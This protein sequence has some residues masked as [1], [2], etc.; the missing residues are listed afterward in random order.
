MPY[1]TTTA[2]RL[3]QAILKHAGAIRDRCRPPGVSPDFDDAAALIDALREYQSWE[4]GQASRIATRAAEMAARE[5]EEAF[6]PDSGVEF[7]ARRVGMLRVLD[8][9]DR[10]GATDE[11][12]G[13]SPADD[14][15]RRMR[16]EA[17]S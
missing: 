5:I 14:V 12:A 8:E 13:V 7:D 6:F 15:A 10:C 1:P 16:R 2:P 17:L 4:M 9:L 3:D 11:V